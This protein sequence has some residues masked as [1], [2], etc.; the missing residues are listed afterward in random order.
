MRVRL[1]MPTTRL[2]ITPRTAVQFVLMSDASASLQL[3][4]G[5]KFFQLDPRIG[6]REL[7]FNFDHCGVAGSFPTTHLVFQNADVRDAAV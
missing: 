5:I 7:P 1:Y 6:T 3:N 2:P 4:S